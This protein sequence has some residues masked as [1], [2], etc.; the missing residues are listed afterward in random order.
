MKAAAMPAACRPGHIVHRKRA[1]WLCRASAGP[2]STFFILLIISLSLPAP[3]AAANLASLQQRG[4]KAYEAG[5]HTEALELF[6]EAVARAPDDAR[7]QYN[8][9]IALYK[10]GN[11]AAAT[12]SFAA[13]ANGLPQQ[14]SRAKAAYNQGHALL[15]AAADNPNPAQKKEQLLTAKHAF[16]QALRDDPHLMAARRGITEF[17]RAYAEADKPSPA[18]RQEQPGSHPQAAPPQQQDGQEMAKEQRRADDRRLKEMAKQ[19]RAAGTDSAGQPDRQEADAMASQQGVRRSIEEIKEE[20]RR[21]GAQEE[22]PMAEDAAPSQEAKNNLDKDSGAKTG[23]RREQIAEHQQQSTGTA[24]D[25]ATTAEPTAS[26]TAVGET[27]GADDQQRRDEQSALIRTESILSEILDG[28]KALH[29]MRRLRMQ[30]QRPT[31]GKDW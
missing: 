8:Q 25:R 14:E 1:S 16:L 7:A 9:G 4:I 31:G 3:L 24:P 29:E 30:Q 21:Q 18:N 12:A 19:S 28:E 22:S 23:N 11:Y 20:L 6:S 10:T 15:S 17:R 27:A 13:A 26:P 5:N 2:W